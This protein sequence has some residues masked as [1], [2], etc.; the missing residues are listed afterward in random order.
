MPRAPTC[1]DAGHRASVEPRT[2]ANAS[3]RT[4]ATPR[5]R[6]RPCDAACRPA[7]ARARSSIREPTRFVLR[8]EP[9]RDHGTLG[10]A[11]DAKGESDWRE[12]T[13]RVVLSDR[14]P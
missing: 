10:V 9:A 14:E 7:Y 2:T 6:T 13:K 1:G 8:V 3:P 4:E 12:A 11:I 5:A